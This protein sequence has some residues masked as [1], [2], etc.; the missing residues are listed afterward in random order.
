MAA[1]VVA[2]VD[3]DGDAWVRP[4]TALDRLRTAT[5]APDVELGDGGAASSRAAGRCSPSP[6]RTAPS[7]GSTWWTA[8]PARDTAR[9]PSARDR[10]TPLT[11]VGRRARGPA[12]ARRSGPWRHGR[13]RRATDLVLQQPGP[14]SS[15]ALVAGRTALLEV[16]LD[17]GD[18]VHA[19]R[20]AG[21]ASPRS[22][23]QVG[24]CAHGAWASP[25]GSYLQL[26]DGGDAEVEQPRG[27]VQRGR[28]GVPGQ[29]AGRRAQRHAARPAVDA[30]AG[31]RPAGAQLDADRARGA[32]RRR[33]GGDRDLGHHAGPRHGVR[34][35]A[36]PA[37]RRG[38][39]VR[40]ARRDGPRSCRSSTTTR[41]PTAASSSIS[42]FDPLPAGVRTRRGDLRRAR[43]AGRRRRRCHRER[44]ADLHDHRR[45]GH[46]RAV[47]RARAAHRARRLD[48]R[49]TGAAAHRRARGSSR[50]G[51]PTT[52]RSPTSSTR[53][54]TTCVLVGAIADPASGIGAVPPGRIRD[55]PGRRSAAGP[56]DR[57]VAGLRRHLDDRGR[58]STSTSARQA[59]CHRRS[60]PCTR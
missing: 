58:G 30:A 8:L 17:G 40:R 60:I 12:P 31:H 5:D 1:G 48:G 47:D 3:A 53:T 19:R 37:D 2:V 24:R 36:G 59:R 15:R 51:R 22:A 38:R 11:A 33:R 26:C 4:L 20:R 25:V 6:P 10:S 41:R 16:P 52:R 32:A 14:Q 55:V 56:H 44:G 23:V 50:A 45:A 34:R 39:R 13:G 42:E 54:A 18:V 29:P 43:A 27:H 9:V 7:P 49:P 35:R 46:Q 21:R 28:A 57:D